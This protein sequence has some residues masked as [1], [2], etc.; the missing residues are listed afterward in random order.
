[1]NGEKGGNNRKDRAR[2]QLEILKLGPPVAAA[3]FGHGRA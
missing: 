1:M 2:V 3:G